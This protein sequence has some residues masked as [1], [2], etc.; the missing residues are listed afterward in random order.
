MHIKR[1]AGSGMILLS[2][3]RALTESW[4]LQPAAKGAP[5]KKREIGQV[6]DADDLGVNRTAWL[7]GA[8][9]RAK[10]KVAGDRKSTR[11]NSSHSQN[12]FPTRRSSDLCISSDPRDPA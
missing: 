1:S 7:G 3:V 4:P 12:S 8:G 11:L 6:R 5:F 10:H 9:E 2:A